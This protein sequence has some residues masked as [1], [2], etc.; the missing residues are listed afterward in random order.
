[1]RRWERAS[2][3]QLLVLDDHF[4][5]RAAHPLGLLLCLQCC[6]LPLFGCCGGLGRQLLLLQR[7]ILKLRCLCLQCVGLHGRSLS[8]GRSSLRLFLC[9]LCLLLCPLCL[10]VELRGVLPGLLRLASRIFCGLPGLCGV[11]AQVRGSCARLVSLCTPRGGCRFRPLYLRLS[12]CLGSDL[13]LRQCRSPLSRRLLH[14]GAPT[15][16]ATVTEAVLPLLFTAC[17]AAAAAVAALRVSCPPSVAAASNLDTASIPCHVVVSAT[18]SGVP[19]PFAR[20][21]SSALTVVVLTA[22]AA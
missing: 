10:L 5:G 1:M 14:A 3:S 11:H 19:V 18:L 22:T 21:I 7:R 2:S 8:L 4:L 6:C 17:G 20:S 9:P 15:W 12:F 13:L 16:R